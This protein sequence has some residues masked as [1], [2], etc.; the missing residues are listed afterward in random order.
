MMLYALTFLVAFL[1][2]LYLTPLFRQAAL[3]FGI[4]DRP[5]GPLKK[6]T[7]PVPYLGG[8]AVYLSFLVT[9]GLIYQYSRE[10]L[11]ILLAGAI[12]V[13]LGLIDDLGVLTPKEK[14]LGQFVAAAVLVKA[15]IY[16]KLSFL[17]LWLAVPLTLLWVVA[18]TNAFNI[19]DIMDGLAAGVGAIA[20]GI[21]V[22][23]N[24]RSGREFIVPLSLALA[25]SLLGFLRYNFKPAK[26]YLGD[27]GSLF[28]GLMLSALSTNGA[29]TRVSLFGL[30]APVMI[31]GVPIFDMLL[32]VYI[33]YRR[34]IPVMQGSPDHFALRLRKWHLSVE[35]TVMACYIASALLGLASLF[36]TRVSTNWVI[37][38]S[39]IILAVCLSIGYYLKRID[40]SL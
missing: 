34:G 13:I 31:L 36:L 5:V 40:M 24:Y 16:I 7:D 37:A 4:V 20:A 33:R 39:S 17:P 2:S 38:I 22:V 23:V 10:V 14:L 19:I 26:I 28:I 9:T 8:L 6:Q 29:Y 11:G 18:I 25:G 1:L 12:I 27:T 30:V 21:L 35:Q 32:V 3:K 15:S